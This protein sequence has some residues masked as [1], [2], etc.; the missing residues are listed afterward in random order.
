MRLA[1]P[2]GPLRRRAL[3]GVHRLELANPG[4]DRASTH[5]Q[6]PRDIGDPA[7]TNLQRLDR[8]IAAP[9]ILGQGSAVQSHGVFVRLV[10]TVKLPHQATHAVQCVV[11]ILSLGS[12]QL[13]ML[14]HL[15]NTPDERP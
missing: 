11:A 15:P 2:L 6:H 3:A 13:N 8:G 1:L 14:T 4:V 5:A 10:V 12:R 9:V 7:A